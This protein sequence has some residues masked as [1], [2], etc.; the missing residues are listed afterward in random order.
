VQ[1]ILAHPQDAQKLAQ[2]IRANR[3]N[4]SQPFTLSKETREVIGE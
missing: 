2:A 1:V 4:Q 3:H